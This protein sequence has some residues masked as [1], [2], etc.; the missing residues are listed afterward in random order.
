MIANCIQTAIFICFGGKQSRAKYNGQTKWIFSP[1][2]STV[3]PLLPLSLSC[4]LEEAW[5]HL[6][7][8]A[9]RFAHT[10]DCFLPLQSLGIFIQTVQCLSRAVSRCLQ[11]MH[12]LRVTIFV[13][14]AIRSVSFCS[15]MNF[16]CDVDHF[17]HHVRMG[18]VYFTYDKKTLVTQT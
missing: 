17:L 5:L 4:V 8:Y 10:P 13:S 18:K 1:V 3:S 9:S 11:S 16:G 14:T 7:R 15:V 6:M 12:F 2:N